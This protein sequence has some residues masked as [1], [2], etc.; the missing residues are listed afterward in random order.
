MM[1]FKEAKDKLK[2]I[3]GDEYHSVT[4]CLTETRPGEY[5][6]QCSIYIHGE[7]R[8]DAPTWEGAFLARERGHEGP[9]QAE[10][11]EMAPE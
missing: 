7:D 8:W 3:A 1:T 4:F 10:A 5:S 9:N 6:T 11:M 2:A